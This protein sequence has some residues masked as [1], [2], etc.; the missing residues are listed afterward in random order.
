MPETRPPRWPFRIVA[1]AALI[2]SAIF[3]AGGGWLFCLAGTVYGAANSARDAISLGMLCGL[4]AGVLWYLAMVPEN[5]RAGSPADRELPWFVFWGTFW[6]LVGW[7]LA[8]VI[9]CLCAAAIETLR[10]TVGRM[11]IW[12]LAF[13]G[14]VGLLGG[15]AGGV[16]VLAAMKVAGHLA[17]ASVEEP[18]CGR[19]A[20]PRGAQETPLWK[21]PL[22]VAVAV[23]LCAAIAVGVTRIVPTKSLDQ[24]I[25]DD[26]ILQVRKHLLWGADVNRHDDEGYTPFFTAVCG[27]HEEVAKLLIDHGADVNLA[28]GTTPLQAATAGF[29]VTSPDSRIRIVKMLIANGADLSSGEG[30]SAAE[31]SLDLPELLRLLIDKGVNLSPPSARGLTLLQLAAAEGHAESVKILLA[32]GAAV[33]GS[34]GTGITPLLLAAAQGHPEVV[35]VL[36]ANKANP[37]VRNREGQTPL[38]LANKQRAELLFEVAAIEEKLSKALTGASA[39][40]EWQREEMEEHKQVSQERLRCAEEVIR[41]LKEHGATE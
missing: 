15:T 4:L 41:L 2:A 31:N 14:A 33:D 19:A 9:F 1:A 20:H 38:A 32:H 7:T 12:S 6:G 35:V 26:D 40:S 18:P 21:R 29:G 36:L 39:F 3:G 16:L 17:Q 11:L 22:L 5:R 25:R 27:G 13:C 24:A 10:Y 34:G 23:V 30:Y 37:N 8:G 28:C